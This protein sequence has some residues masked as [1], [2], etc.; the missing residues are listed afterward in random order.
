MSDL[1]NSKTLLIKQ[2]NVCFMDENIE[3]IGKRTLMSVKDREVYFC[4][5]VFWDSH[6]S[7]FSLD[8]GPFR[9]EN[10]YDVCLCCI[11]AML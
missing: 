4:F 8:I 5:L 2:Y 6:F 1:P 3:I 10:V 11:I 9:T 7:G